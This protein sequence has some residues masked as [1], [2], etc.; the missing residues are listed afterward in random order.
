MKRTIMTLIA[1]LG[2]IGC[3]STAIAQQEKPLPPTDFSMTKMSD[4]KDGTTFLLKFKVAQQGT[5]PNAFQVY[6]APGK[7]DSKTNFRVIRS[8]NAEHNNT[9]YSFIM[10]FGPGQSSFF[11]TS[12]LKQNGAFLESDPSNFVYLTVEGNNQ[13]MINIVSKPEHDGKAITDTVWQYQLKAEANFQTTINYAFDGTVPDGLTIDQSTGLVSWTPTTL[14]VFEFKVKAYSVESP[15]IFA[16]QPL[17][18][19]VVN[20]D[21]GKPPV[22][23]AKIN[24]VIKFEDGTTATEGEIKIWLVLN[25]VPQ[26]ILFEAKIGVDGTYSIDVPTG[27]YI[28]M[29]E[30]S[31]FFRKYWENTNEL[32]DAIV[33]SVACSTKTEINLTVIKRTDDKHPVPCSKISGTIKFDDTTPV[34]A[35]FVKAWVVNNSNKDYPKFDAK[36]AQ[37]GSYSLDVPAGNYILMVDGPSFLREYWENTNDIKAATTITVA[38]NTTNEFNFAVTKKVEPV[39]YKVS[40]TVIDAATNAPLLAVVGFTPNGN[41]GNGID[42]RNLSVR[43]DKDGKYTIELSNAFTYTAFARPAEIGMGYYGQYFDHVSSV[44]EASTLVL[45]ADRTDINFGLVS[46]QTGEKGKLS[47]VVLDSNKIGLVSQVVAYLIDSQ[48]NSDK[49]FIYK[50][51]ATSDANG[52]FT[53]DNLVYGNYVIFSAPDIKDWI[54]GYLVDGKIVSKSWKDATV[55]VIDIAENGSITVNHAAKHEHGIAHI[56][57]RVKEGHHQLFNANGNSNLVDTYV[58]GTV[59]Y[60]YSSSGEVIDFA[61]AD[62]DGNY[63]M[64]GLSEGTNTLLADKVGY[65]PSITNVTTDYKANRDVTAD[66]LLLAQ[67]EASVND[68]ITIGVSVYPNPANDVVN[69]QLAENSNVTS[70]EL[71][72]LSGAF[73]VQPAY[74]LSNGIVTIQ[75]NELGTGIYLMSIETGNSSIRVPVVIAR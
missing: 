18:I 55:V 12:G 44:L 56:K 37:D 24:G 2:F 34:T 59:L 73:R 42:N 7:T 33:I 8:M 26:R 5:V 16:I 51:T 14:G 71:I 61:I 40:G 53:L 38:C 69:V 22:A 54:P 52:N 19:T 66:V 39:K 48:N 64:Q 11:V 23:C 10:A 41:N 49:K 75:L 47:G 31:T 1:V 3:L 67:V 29:A 13:Q 43:T 20:S 57:G 72:D 70:V 62:A 4:G 74:N 46:V 65:D 36:I 58:P 45:S 17:R 21:D 50:V 60:V 68:I 9:E 35:G 6:Q 32:K 30:G 25:K 27:D 15:N 63:L 28:V